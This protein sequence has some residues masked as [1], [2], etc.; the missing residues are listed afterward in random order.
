MAR[1]RYT[2]LVCMFH[3]DNLVKTQV[4]RFLQIFFSTHCGHGYGTL[5]NILCWYAY[6]KWALL[7]K[8]DSF[9]SF[10]KSHLLSMFQQFQR[11]IYW[12]QVWRKSREITTVQNVYYDF[13]KVLAINMQKRDF[14]STKFYIPI[15]AL[16]FW[17][18]M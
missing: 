3:K 1:V 8:N 9:K 7:T 4:G 17:K 5:L 12:C 15:N 10:I 2:I 11:T 18:L 16:H 6:L 13:I 14:C